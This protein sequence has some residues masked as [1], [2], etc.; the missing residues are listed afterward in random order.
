MFKKREIAFG[1]FWRILYVGLTGYTGA[2]FGVD[3]PSNPLSY[4]NLTIF[5]PFSS[6]YG[7]IR[8][9]YYWSIQSTWSRR[10][11]QLSGI[12]MSIPF[13]SCSIHNERLFS[14]SFCCDSVYLGIQKKE[15]SFPVSFFHPKIAQTFEICGFDFKLSD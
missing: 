12:L 7:W 3:G 11:V 10:R 1:F 2:S 4:R 13:L 14:S 5:S 8:C 9:Q 15:I 6:K